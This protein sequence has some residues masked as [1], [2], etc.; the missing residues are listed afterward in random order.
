MESKSEEIWVNKEQNLQY[1]RNLSLG[2]PTTVIPASII[3]TTLRHTHKCA[4]L[5][6]PSNG[7]PFKLFKACE[8]SDKH[9]PR[10]CLISKM[11]L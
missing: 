10:G 2:R 5:G 8:P 11:S 1:A 7:G 6:R 3:T 4:H 9:N